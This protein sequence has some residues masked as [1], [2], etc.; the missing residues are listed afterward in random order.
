MN[1]NGILRLKRLASEVIS[2]QDIDPVGDIF[3]DISRKIFFNHYGKMY[4]NMD[5]SLYQIGP[6]KHPLYPNLVTNPHFVRDDG[7]VVYIELLANDGIYLKE[8]DEETVQLSM[9]I[10]KIKNAS[11]FTVTTKPNINIQQIQNIKNIEE[12]YENISERTIKYVPEIVKNYVSN[13]GRKKYKVCSQ[14]PDNNSG[15]NTLKTLDKFKK[16]DWVSA[17]KTR[18]FA[19]ND[20]LID[21][22]DSYNKGNRCHKQMDEFNFTHFIMNKGKQFEENVIKL[23]KQKVKP[24]EFV[25]IC[26]DMYDYDKKILEYESNTIAEILK[27]TPIIYQGVLMNRDGP[28]EYSYGMP[29]LLVRSDYLPKIVDLNPLDDGMQHFK[30]PKLNGNYHYVVVDIKFTTLDLCA[31]GKRIRNSGSSPAYK[32]QIYVYNHAV[33]KIQGFEPDVSFIL[34]RKYKYESKNICYSNNSCFARFGHIDYKNWDNDYIAETISAIGWIKKLRTEGEKWKLLPVPSVP[35]L[36]PNMSSIY[37]SKWETLKTEYA[38]QIGE[39]TLLW[40][41]G[42]KNREICHKNGIYSYF[43]PKC[44]PEVLGIKGQK[45]IPVLDE[46]I[47]INRKKNFSSD[48]DKIF[49]KINKNIN[50]GWM[51]NFQLRIAVDFEMINSIFDNFKDL[52]YAQDQNYLFMVG[53][54]YQIFGQKTEY[55]MFLA[56]ELSKD[57]EFQMVYQFY[58][59]LRELTDKHI[60]KGAA[61][62]PLYHWGHIERSFFSGLCDRLQKNIGPNI[63]DDI[64]LMKTELNW[65]DLLESFR[66]NPIVINGC[67]GFGLKEIASRLSELGF[68]K[69]TWSTQSQCHDGN[70]AMIIAQKAYQI[71]KQDNVP[72]IQIPLMKEI[73]EYNRIDCTVIHEIIDFMKKKMNF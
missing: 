57:A 29:D 68:I 53:I 6:C 61:I 14:K 38:K 25:T 28:L 24:D 12:I 4:Q 59:F 36:Y 9:E 5:I 15:P 51:D 73:I 43:D 62:P 71:S 7:V 55:K 23:V 34:G 63:K 72:V 19:L 44:S 21:W 26:S 60:G 69:S 16:D 56:S 30:A 50:N 49:M 17:S 13:F 8:I 42:V 2:E 40:N 20:T 58:K 45:Q 67:F 33:G 37:E 54:S 70:A 48:M 32:C 10:L 41:C 22:L 66:G 47:K 52:P 3:L 46:I 35:E 64:E 18:N 1:K 39:L 27:G 11:I 31:D 65:F